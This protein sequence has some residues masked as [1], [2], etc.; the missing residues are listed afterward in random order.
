M[1]PPRTARVQN[2]ELLRGSAIIR[3]RRGAGVRN[4][5]WLP[6]NG[7]FG[8]AFLFVRVVEAAMT[9]R[10]LMRAVFQTFSDVGW[11]AVRRG[12]VVGGA[13]AGERRHELGSGVNPER[14]VDVR[15]PQLDRADRQEQLLG[16]LA[17]CTPHG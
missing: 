2:L 15:E 6:A 13:G 4:G 17:V 5:L 8:P 9:L 14:A 12:A 11:S 10:A 16:D 3:E 1:H 7:L